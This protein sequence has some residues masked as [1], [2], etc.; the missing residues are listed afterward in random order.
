MKNYIIWII[1]LIIV[2]TWIWI[3]T[4]NDSS[5]EVTANNSKIQILSNNIDVWEIPMDEW[6][7]KIP[8]EFTNTWTWDIVLWNAE[9]SCMCTDAIITSLDWNYQS[10]TI[11][12]Q[13]HWPLVNLKKLIKPNEKLVLV[14][15]FDP[16]AHW[17]NAT[18]PIS[19][20]IYIKTNSNLTPELDFKFTWNVVKTRAIDKSQTDNKVSENTDV[21]SFE[22]KSFDF[23][24]IKQSGWKVSH[25]FKFTYNWTEP[26]KVTWVPTSCACTSA[27]IDK[28]ELNP[29]D[30]WILTVNFN[31]NLHEEPEW[32][33]FKSV[34][35]LTDRKLEEIPEVKIWTQIDLDLWPDAF[36]LKSD[37]DDED[38]HEEVSYHSITSEEF[39]TMLQSKDFF[40]VDT[41]IPEQEHIEWTDI[42]IPYNEIED[43]LDKLP[44]DKN[45]KIVVYCRSG[46]MS[47]ATA[48]ILVEK[49]YT[50]VYDVVGGKNWYDNYK[51]NYAKNNEE[52]IITLNAK[53]WEYDKREIRIKKWEKVIIKVNNIDTLHGIAIPEMKLIWDTEIE[54][55]TSKTWEFEFR[56]ANY[57][58]AG[59]QDMIWKIIIE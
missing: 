37:H 8:F 3:Y 53:R 10:S 44:K 5:S 23:W 11:Q 41:H 18:W 56:C 36:E 15:I 4:L 24:T 13:W 12:M 31:P 7:L 51:K 54:V 34:T 49:G 50:N 9:T 33:F 19:R 30:T 45:A 17:P 58:G 59:H 38:E 32:K 27:T 35:L 48:Y 47:R 6:K 16:N 55:D 43:N 46:S 42:F 20:D 1:A 25:D 22:E 21:F 39:D 40:L 57:C 52:K 14:A 28:T 2:W 29:W 26:I